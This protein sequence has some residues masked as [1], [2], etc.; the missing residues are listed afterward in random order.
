ML[1]LDSEAGEHERASSLLDANGLYKQGYPSTGV[2][3]G[4]A[5]SVD[6]STTAFAFFLRVH[7]RFQAADNTCMAVMRFRYRGMVGAQ[8]L[9]LSWGQNLPL[10]WC[11][12][13]H[14]GTQRLVRSARKHHQVEKV[15][16]Q[17]AQVLNARRK[18]S[19]FRQMGGTVLLDEDMHDRRRLCISLH[20]STAGHSHRL[21]SLH[22]VA[23]SQATS[24]SSLKS[25]RTNSFH[26]CFWESAGER[27]SESDSG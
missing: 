19:K 16:G 20:M 18:C 25:K 21:R 9:R 13:S 10:S 7:G 5:Q 24:P 12:I 22:Q 27:I 1:R 26:Y 8:S 14:S 17:T 2:S 15:I 6:G 11:S 3:T 4:P 23:P